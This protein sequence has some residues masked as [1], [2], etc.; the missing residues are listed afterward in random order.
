M[1]IEV[2]G[3]LLRERAESRCRACRLIK[4]NKPWVQWRGAT[5]YA[6]CGHTCKKDMAAAMRLAHAV[7]YDVHVLHGH[8]SP[9]DVCPL[10]EPLHARLNALLTPAEG[11]QKEE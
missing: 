1:L 8:L 4:R 3:M 10:C 11:G 2:D 5:Y 6:P 7:L 9:P